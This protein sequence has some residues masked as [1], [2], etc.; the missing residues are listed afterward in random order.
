MKTVATEQYLEDWRRTTSVIRGKAM[1]WRG[2][3]M[4]LSLS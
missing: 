1:L 2:H 3:V 4:Q